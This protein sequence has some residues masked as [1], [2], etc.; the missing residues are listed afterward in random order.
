MGKIYKSRRVF[1]KIKH[2]FMEEKT[3]KNPFYDV[4]LHKE[5]LY[6]GLHYPLTE[7]FEKEVPVIVTETTSHLEH[8]KECEHCGTKT[9]MKRKDAKYCTS[10]CRKLAYLERRKAKA[11]EKNED[12]T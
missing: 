3:V 9:W 1:K 8:L 6:K 7:Y 2:Q 4:K 10:S 11:K 5:C 12:T